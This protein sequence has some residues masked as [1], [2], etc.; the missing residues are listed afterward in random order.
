MTGPLPPVDNRRP[1][2]QATQSESSLTTFANG[3]H[4]PTHKTYHGVHTISPY[5]IQGHAEH[6]RH[7]FLDEEEMH[8]PI[9][10][11]RRMKSGN[12]SSSDLLS[13]SSLGLRTRSNSIV[14][15][16]QMQQMPLEHTPRQ[17]TSRQTMGRGQA[18]LSVNTTQAQFNY[19]DNFSHDFLQSA[20][21]D[22]HQFSAGLHPSSG[23]PSLAN[24]DFDSLYPGLTSSSSV[25]DNDENSIMTAEFARSLTNTGPVPSEASDIGDDGYRL[26]ATSSF[27]GMPHTGLLGGNRLDEYSM[28]RFMVDFLSTPME[29]T[30]MNLE[31]YLC[32]GSPQQPFVD[33][34]T[35]LTL[36]A[37]SGYDPEQS[38]FA[39]SYLGQQ[40]IYE[41]SE[42]LDLF[43][44]NIHSPAD[45][46][47]LLNMS[48]PAPADDEGLVWMRKFS[49][50]SSSAYPTNIDQ[51]WNTQSQS[52]SPQ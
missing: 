18:G 22:V 26:S 20:D 24:I 27:I 8:P 38:L 45:S 12:S 43:A 16:E 34:A 1:K 44:S 42:S 17:P 29:T 2:L 14:A 7:S 37:D 50:A 31:R 36:T 25:D 13:L 19:H 9:S 48:T 10:R 23:W 4:K 51:A 32:D 15:L 3:H 5:T 46:N 30:R 21:S 52:Q 11:H 6:H 28:E 40:T 49:N 33:P 41:S 39:G 35:N 47:I